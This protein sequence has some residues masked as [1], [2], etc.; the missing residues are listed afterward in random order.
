MDIAWMYSWKS[1][2]PLF[3]RKFVLSNWETVN[4]SISIQSG[5]DYTIHCESDTRYLM[6]TFDNVHL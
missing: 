4:I 5:D 6:D 2:E 1:P 3:V